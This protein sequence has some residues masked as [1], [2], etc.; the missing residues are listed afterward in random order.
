VY[1]FVIDENNLPVLVAGTLATL[2]LIWVALWCCYLRP[3]SNQRCC[4]CCTKLDVSEAKPVDDWADAQF[5]VDRPSI[6]E[7]L[8]KAGDDSAANP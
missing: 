6:A 8:P 3:N 2:V 5:G 4:C 7:L 1:S